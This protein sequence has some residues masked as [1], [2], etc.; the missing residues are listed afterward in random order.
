MKYLTYVL[1]IIMVIGA[2]PANAGFFSNVKD[3]ATDAAHKV[4]DKASEVNNK[5]HVTDKAKDA[6]KAGV[7]KAKDSGL[8]DK[9]KDKAQNLAK[10]G[11]EKAQE[12][13]SR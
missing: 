10:Q 6:A 2:A 7:Q 5:Y 13:I 1:A 12:R 11:A 9:A 4:Q 8:L 3:K